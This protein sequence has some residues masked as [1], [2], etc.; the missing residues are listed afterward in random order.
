MAYHRPVE[1]QSFLVA[2]LDRYRQSKAQKRL[3][4]MP[5]HLRHK[6]HADFY[7]GTRSLRKM[8]RSILFLLMTEKPADPVKVVHVRARASGLHLVA[9]WNPYP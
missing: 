9:G 7:C 3:L 5:E 8:C 6:E 2:T 4:Q 1:W